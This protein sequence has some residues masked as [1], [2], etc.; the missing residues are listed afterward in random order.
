MLFES[1]RKRSWRFSSIIIKNSSVF[2]AKTDLHKHKYK[3]CF[4]KVNYHLRKV[5]GVLVNEHVNVP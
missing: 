5:S 2:Y 1:L 4:N 3:L